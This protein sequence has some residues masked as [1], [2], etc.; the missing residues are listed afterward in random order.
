MI[1]VSSAY[2]RWEM[3][4]PGIRASLADTVK[5][6]TGKRIPKS[7]FVGFFMP[8]ATGQNI[9]L[10]TEY[11]LFTVSRIRGLF[12]H[13]KGQTHKLNYFLL[14]SPYISHFQTEI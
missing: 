5:G 2:W 1:M 9:P 4:P 13:S 11:S 7:R 6:R 12:R 3:S 10:K 14:I 8:R